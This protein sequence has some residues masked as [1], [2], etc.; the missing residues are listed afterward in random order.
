MKTLI[1]T[2]LASLLTYAD[3]HRS[4]AEAE[5]VLKDSREDVIAALKDSEGQTAEVKHADGATSTL[6]LTSQTRTYGI[7]AVAAA[8]IEGI[9]P[10]LLQKLCS[11]DTDKA[12]TL[13]KAGLINQ[14]QFDALTTVQTNAMIRVTTKP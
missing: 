4:K 14:A 12:K 2:A 9:G 8:K 11:V 5:K 3:A 6:L 13:L 10:A 1:A 7:D